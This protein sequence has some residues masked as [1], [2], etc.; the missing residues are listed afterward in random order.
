MIDFSVKWKAE[1][2]TCKVDNYDFYSCALSLLCIDLPILPI[3]P[4]KLPDIY[5]DFSNIDL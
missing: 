3:P 1:C 5:V 2:S 4:F